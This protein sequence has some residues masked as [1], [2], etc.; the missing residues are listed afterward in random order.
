MNVLLIDNNPHLQKTLQYFLHPYA[1]SIYCMG[2]HEEL[3]EKIDIIFLDS[4]HTGNEYISH[5]KNKEEKPP[6]VLIS[7]DEKT[8]TELAPEYPASLK[9]PI[10]YSQLQNIIHHLIPETKSFKASPYL[11]FYEPP[12]DE[13]EQPINLIA[14]P[15]K[16][17]TQKT[18]QKQTSDE[19]EQPITLSEEPISTTEPQTPS[20]NIPLTSN[21]DTSTDKNNEPQSKNMQETEKE[22]PAFDKKQAIVIP[23]DIKLVDETD[24]TSLHNTNTFL[25]KVSESIKSKTQAF[26]K[27]HINKNEIININAANQKDT[28]QET[29]VNVLEKKESTTGSQVLTSPQED[30][31]TE[32]DIKEPTGSQ[33][34]KSPE[35]NSEAPTSTETAVKEPT[36]SKVLQESDLE[37][38]GYLEDFSMDSDI[39]DIE[40]SQSISPVNNV[41]SENNVIPESNVIPAKAGIQ[42]TPAFIEKSQT[43]KWD[44]LSDKIVDIIDKHFQDKWET[45]INTQLKQNIK[46]MIHKEVTQVFKEQMKD[47]LTTEGIQSIKKASEEISWKVI[48]ELSRQII[49]KEIKKLLDKKSVK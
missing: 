20:A 33:V 36:G 42:P 3:P 18:E 12:A 7:R 35:E 5:L 34:L 21:R 22:Q 10:Q 14:E 30:S 44:T 23:D 17:P 47:I 32:E 28:S 37:Q 2:S 19:Q 49:Q 48:P 45:F 40:K 31:K 46:E 6:I 29:S 15:N 38:E 11:K 13:Q 1:P 27:P 16:E 8:L 24:S 4:E 26:E 9:K 25:K 43:E 41:T 39:S